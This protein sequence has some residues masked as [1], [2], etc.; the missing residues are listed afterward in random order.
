[1][2]FATLSECKGSS[3]S[4]RKINLCMLEKGEKTKEKWGGWS[5]LLENPIRLLS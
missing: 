1:M 2:A 3:T 4:K 5:E